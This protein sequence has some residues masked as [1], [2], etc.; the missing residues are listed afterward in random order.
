MTDEFAARRRVQQDEAIAALLPFAKDFIERGLEAAPE[1]AEALTQVYVDIY[2]GEG[3]LRQAR[4]KAF[5]YS[6]RSVL[7]H[8]EPDSDPQTVATWLA[9]A[10]INAATVQAAADEPRPTA[11]KWTTMHDSKVRE[12]HA[13]A[14]GQ[15]R[16]AGS[17]FFVGGENLRYP[18]DPRGSIENTI[19]CRCVLQPVPYY[20]DAASL[21]AASKETTMPLDAPLAWHGV[22]APE[23][24]WSGDG[25]RFMT[26]SL[27]NRDLPL[28]LTWQKASSDGHDTSVVIGRIDSIER[29]IGDDGVN[30][31]RGEG[32]F[33]DTPETDEFVG[34]LAEF[35]RFGVSVDA[36]DSEFEFDEDTGKVSF[37]SARI[38]S[39]CCVAIPAFASAFIAMG[40]WAEADG[41]SIADAPVVDM[42]DPEAE[43][44]PNA[45]DYEEC[46]AQKAQEV[47]STDG[48]EVE[49]RLGAR[50]DHAG[51]LAVD[52]R[53]ELGRVR[54][55]GASSED[56]APAGM[57]GTGGSHSNGTATGSPLSHSTVR[58]PGSSGTGHESGER[59]ARPF[60]PHYDLP[61]RASSNGGQPGGP[62]RQAEVSGVRAGSRQELST[63]TAGPGVVEMISDAAWDGSAG[64]FTN[65]QWKKACVLHVCTGDEK[66]CHKLPIKE[67]GGALSRAGV[68]AAASR[69]NQVDA[70]PEAKASAARALRGAYKQ[71]GEEP[72]DVLKASL[73][74]A[75]ANE[76]DT[77]VDLHFGRGPGWLTNPVETKRIHDYWT[78]PGNAGYAKV[79]WGVPGDFNRCRV[80]IGEEIGES[81][82]DTLR[83]LNQICA[84][85]HH[86][87]TGFW[88]GHAPAEVAAGAA[89]P[90]LSLV[91]SGV[92][93]APAA[94]FANPNLE[95][96]THL[97]VTEEGRVF[98]HIAAWGTCH[99]GYDGVCVTPP[100]SA[101]GYAYYATGQV[102]L[103]DGRYAST[104][105]ISLGGGH[106]GIRHGF[107]AAAAHYDSTS[108]AVADVSVGEDEHGIW[109]AGWVRP[110]VGADTANALMASDI[111]GDWREIGGKMEM[112]AAL[113]VN[114]AGFPVAAVRDRVQVAL[115]AAGVV[116]R[117]E[118]DIAELVNL[119]IQAAF[120]RRAKMAK[121]RA[122][123]VDWTAEAA[124]NRQRRMA[125]LR[126]RVGAI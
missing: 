78:V 10:T 101:S 113:A 27:R 19:N 108:S 63:A 32:T 102:P 18:G 99:V 1:L 116:H 61:Q 44:D 43:C 33:V 2:L 79:N 51:S 125:E 107:R 93:K 31:M 71:L 11:L 120:E 54:N 29:V 4:T 22:L 56:G 73:Q 92:T 126:E 105:V 85:W 34:L 84:Q 117:P 52:R 14:E 114:V 42:T 83:F 58:Q 77:D 8:T 24:E 67:P 57:G 76:T 38:A 124:A 104:G 48:S 115:V 110:G 55:V 15:R 118:D 23:N 100:S 81:S 111:S 35:G 59:A 89:G 65:E 7:T 50:V 72:P 106:A 41:T 69:F 12:A 75:G 109:C 91:A 46:L 95:G 87:A 90:A 96:P 80:E 119:G 60:L 39:A 3:G 64:R 122:R 9:V 26:D 25:R 98:G 17:F 121:L 74:S 5:I 21:T 103:D 123:S 20:P 94:W 82:P 47:D 86:D 28:P 49:P 30:L 45:P 53:D 13:V 37:S 6:M 62:G 66:S 40:T 112:I 70:P 97:T 16:P 88:P 68:H 36:D